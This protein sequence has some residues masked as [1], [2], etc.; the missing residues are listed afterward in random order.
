MPK[1][2]TG[3]S[4]LSPIQPLKLPLA[5]IFPARVRLTILDNK[6]NPEIFNN[7]GEWN[8]IGCIFFDKVNNPNP[9]KSVTTNSFARP[10]FPNSSITP[11]NNEIV[12][13]I[14][15]PN[16]NIQDNVNDISYY[17]FQPIN[18]WNST[19]HNAIPDPIYDNSM[20]E[21][22]K[23]DYE[24]TQIG[25]VRRVSDNSTEIN[26]GNTFEEK[27]SIKN[28]Q[29]YEG[30]IIHQGRWGQSI[31]FSSTVKNA[32]IPN[33][34]SDSGDNGDPITIIRNGQHDDGNDP[35]VPQVEDINE[36]LS[37]IWVTSTQQVPLNASS[38]SYNSY[39]TKPEDVQS[40]KEEQIVLNSGRL[41]FNTKKD[42]I[43]LSSF[44]TINLNSQDSVNI[45][46]PKTIIASQEVLL[47]DKNAS[48]SV[49]LGDKFLG[50]LSKLLNSLVS[51]CNALST[52]IGTPQ[53]F[54]PNVAIPAPAAQT[55]VK[56]QSMLNKIEQYKSKVS[57]SK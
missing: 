39:Q 22:Q 30:D 37:S 10:L 31:R 19:H 45:D 12:Y 48:E 32:E 57:K 52:P 16:S 42:S 36:D 5:N 7:F 8:S 1:V 20:P 27:L 41:F 3:L 4:S 43:L 40:Y 23:Q 56:A 38:T 49:I 28:L 26:L 14:S 11:V 55:L 15:L 50:D 25:V 53:P 18:I 33:T 2:P 13:I 17:Y 44:K 24:Q 21:S 47:G 34:W 35:W 54:V 46:S 9:N 51:L 6:T 29:P